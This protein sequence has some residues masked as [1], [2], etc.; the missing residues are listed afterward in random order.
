M[1][2]L[3]GGGWFLHR[4]P[5]WQ[6]CSV[7]WHF[8]LALPFVPGPPQKRQ[9]Q[10]VTRHISGRLHLKKPAGLKWPP[11]RLGMHTEIVSLSLSLTVSHSLALSFSLCG[12]RG[13]QASVGLFKPLP[14]RY[15]NIRKELRKGQVWNCFPNTLGV[16]LR[17]D[18]MRE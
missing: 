17:D 16:P 8:F 15:Q 12:W 7:R 9:P 4:W 5:R 6:V 2:V 1:F 10:L 3:A 11:A 13:I 18:P 14:F